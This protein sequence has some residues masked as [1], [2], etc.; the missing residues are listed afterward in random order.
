MEQSIGSQTFLSP[1][2]LGLS[3]CVSG[4]ALCCGN[5]EHSEL[6]DW[7]DELRVFIAQLKGIS[8]QLFVADGT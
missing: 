2:F 3:L 4:L 6:E 5:G 8:E 1:S 7:P